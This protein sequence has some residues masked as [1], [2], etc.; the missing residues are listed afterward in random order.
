MT[1]VSMLRVLVAD[2]DSQALAEL[3]RVLTELGHSVMPYAVDT[4]EAAERIAAED[5]DVAIVMVHEDAEHALALVEEAVEYASGPV[6]A[7][8]EGDPE[9]VARAADRGIAA[10]VPELS[11]EAIQS[12]LEVALRRHRETNELSDRVDQL[13]TALD[14]RGVIER[15]KGILMERHQV[16]ERE[17]FDLLRDQ[18]R[19]TGRRVVD[20][21]AAVSEGHA[22]LPK[23]SSDA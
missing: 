23:S 6:L 17:A 3:D 10:W 2:E 11:P 18:A 4:A 22:L 5:P 7:H 12:T 16:G 15:A 20:L 14:R 9:L 21:A 19:N 13:Q 8:I 1:T